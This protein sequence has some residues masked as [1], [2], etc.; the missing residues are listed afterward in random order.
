MKDI[1]SKMEYLF[2]YDRV[3]G[4]VSNNRF[5]LQLMADLTSQV[6]EKSRFTDMTN[7]GAAF[8]AGLGQGKNWNFFLSLSFGGVGCFKS[9]FFCLRQLGSR[10]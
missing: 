3:N 10:G 2:F 1:V 8:L 6:I 9:N 5:V 7:L 4:G